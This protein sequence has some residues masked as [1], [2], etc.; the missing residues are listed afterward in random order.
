[1]SD[2][3]DLLKAINERAFDKI[4]M[5]SLGE[6]AKDLIYKRTKSGIGVSSLKAENPT[7]RKLIP[8]S[9]NYIEFRKTVNLGRFGSPRRSNLTFTGQMLDSLEVKAQR[10]NFTVF[11]PEKQRSSLFDTD[12]MTNAAVA[13][14][15]Q[16]KRPFLAL[17]VK[18]QRILQRK[19][20]QHFRKVIRNI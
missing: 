20:D 4:F 6:D 2:L 13:R 1:M 12:G 17:T 11:V 16:K 19:I 14:D 18:E 5:K 9:E 7:E 8:L 3:N 15:V 10:F